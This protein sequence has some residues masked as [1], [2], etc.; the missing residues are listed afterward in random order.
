MKSYGIMFH[1]FHGGLHP[2]GQG[3]IS[4]DDF[5][6]MLDWL[7]QRYR[8]LDARSFYEAA[9]S[10][11][12]TDEDTCLTFDDSLLCQYEIAA[13]IL[14]DQ[15]VT[16]FYF[17][18]SSAFT[19]EP[20][21]LEIYRY[22]RSTEFPDFDAFFDAFMS[23]VAIQQEETVT[24]ALQGFDP[25]QYLADCSFYSRNDRLFRYLR[26]RVLT[27][28]QY[29]NVMAGLMEARHFKIREVYPLIFMDSSHLVDLHSAGNVIGL[30]SHTHP[31]DMDA[32]GVADQRDEYRTNY[33]FISSTVGEE[34]AS[35]A[36]PCGRY[37]PD[38]LQILSDLGVRLG[39][40]ASL[41]IPEA[42]SLLEIPREDHANILA[43]MRS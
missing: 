29:S 21:M 34:P 8:V 19:D 31:T 40:R 25:D 3:S 20:D 22:F 9:V 23:Q 11:V 15:G 35:M 16:A 17:V 37:T 5:V 14:A 10:G 12:L 30:H 42:P 7:R 43:R 39:F 33:A 27:K 1:H 41:S 2:L 26:D 6:E 4:A 18:Y 28:D 24:R 32:L 13:P 38:T 36:H